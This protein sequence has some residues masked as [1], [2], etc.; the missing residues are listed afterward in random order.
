[1]TM[2][3]TPI[4]L[5][6]AVA[7]VLALALLPVASADP[8]EDAAE[9][10]RRFAAGVRLLQQG[11]VAGALGEFEA[12]RAIHETASVTFNIAG[13]LRT[14]GRRVEAR[15]AYRRVLEIT[16]TASQRA[17]ARRG[18]QQIE[19]QL[20]LVTVRVQPADAEISVDGRLVTTQPIPL[21]PGTGH[22][23]EARRQGHRTVRH[24]LEPA[25]A[26]PTE[27]VLVLE[28]E[29]T[30]P[31]AAVEP[32]R[33][34][35]RGQPQLQLAAA[36]HVQ[37]PSPVAATSEPR[38]PPARESSGSTWPWILGGAGVA[39]AVAGAVV[40]AVL[41]SNGSDPSLSGDHEFF[42]VP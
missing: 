14:L 21:E 24:R 37:G 28:P 23:V 7:V 20:A 15:E 41:L 27:L 10:D 2:R 36:A 39:V 13:C 32:T 11:N 4:A 34:G 25:A 8:R 1:M 29:A 18:L 38:R 35:G 33:P 31:A 22:D 16:Q 5:A 6:S 19:A 17:A 26:G 42:H 9:A 40:A 12:S 3:P 30:P